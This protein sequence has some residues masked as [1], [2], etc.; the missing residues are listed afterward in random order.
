MPPN[1]TLQ[2]LLDKLS[3]EER[4]ADQLAQALQACRPTTGTNAVILKM[5]ALNA[6]N[7]ARH[8]GQP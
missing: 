7:D 5:K 1:N 6:Y 4:L 2:H 3:R 8:K